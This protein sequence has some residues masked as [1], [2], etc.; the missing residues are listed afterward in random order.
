MSAVVDLSGIEVEVD[1]KW[2]VGQVVEG[3]VA[4][5]GLV[6]YAMLPVSILFYLFIYI[7]LGF[8]PSC[9]ILRD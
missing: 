3:G 5:L 6:Q 9:S 1:S 2:F 8:A 7:S 4:L